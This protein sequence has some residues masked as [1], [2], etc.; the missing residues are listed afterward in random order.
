MASAQ[1][2]A[3]TRIHMPPQFVAVQAGL[4]LSAPYHDDM[5]TG[6]GFFLQG[7]YVLV[8]TAWF[9][10]RAYAGTLITFSSPDG[11]CSD[12]DIGCEVS[13]K[14]GFLGAKGRL[15]IPI[16]YIAPFLEL[17]V[18]ASI[19]S[20]RTRTPTTNEKLA[21]VTYHI[22]VAVGLSLGE[23][24]NW[25]LMFSFL[26]HPSEK[27]VGGAIALGLSFQVGGSRP[28]HAPDSLGVR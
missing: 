22:P 14:I 16:P 7:E 11:Y 21:G 4:G 28:S 5:S 12:Q 3:R 25:D 15:T 8:P 9:S 1:N 10:P 27:Q 13:A 2:R 18:G 24:H 6:E 20:M 26:Y 17:G 23:D 19:G